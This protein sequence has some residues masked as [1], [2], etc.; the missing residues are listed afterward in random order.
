MDEDHAQNARPVRRV[1]GIPLRAFVPNAVTALALCFGL[2]GVRAA[3]TGDWAMTLGLIVGAG[4]LDGVD[5]RIARLL[6]ANTRFGAELDSLSDV[7]AFGVAPAM[8]IYL[9]SLAAA[10]KFG[11]T[12]ALSLTV[13]CAL[14][15]ARFNANIDV[16]DQPH[17]SAGFN[18]GIPAPVGAGCALLPLYLWLVTDADLFRAWYS[19]MPWVIF[20]A[21]LMISNVATY[22]WSSIR[23]RREWRLAAIAFVGMLGAAIITA[24]W[25]TLIAIVALYLGSIPFSMISYARVRQQRQLLGDDGAPHA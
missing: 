5:G 12:A 4:V 8:T 3:L 14:R 10:P 23:L 15:L 20:I 2:S 25:H 1:N 22:N 11:W 17:K 7:I 6:K 9:W 18:T 19:V 24:P 16:K 13:C 21:F